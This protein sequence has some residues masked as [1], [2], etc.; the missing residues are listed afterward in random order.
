MTVAKKSLDL[1]QRLGAREETVM[2]LLCLSMYQESLKESSRLLSESLILARQFG[3]Q[4]AIG[5]TLV[6]M[7][8]NAQAVG[9]YAN[10]EQRWREALKQFRQNRDIRATAW[11]LTYLSVLVGDRGRYEEALALAQ[12]NMSLF[13]ESNPPTPYVFYALGKALYDLG[14]YEAA[15][16]QF[17]Q[18]LALT[19]EVGLRSQNPVNL[20]FLGKIA[21]RTGDYAR[22]HQHHEESLAGALEFD[23]LEL[24][25]QNHDAL[26]RLYGAQSAGMRAREHCRAALQAAIAFGQSQILLDCLA[27]VAELIL[28]EGNL[29]QA[30]MMAM[31]IT[32]HPNSRAKTK[33]RAGRL[34]IKS[35]VDLSSGDLADKYQRGR[36]SDLDTVAAQVLVDLKTL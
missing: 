28:E 12:E 9:D 24:V 1:L 23:N 29:D 4:W 27:T 25:A 34:L 7:G 30:A 16:E 15:E 19:K 17:Q 20:F 32:N 36:Q 33:E 8:E 35:E 11:A 2:P 10:A 5:H 31:P 6:R 18:R 14:T 22:A 3:D 26:G 13:T 21:F